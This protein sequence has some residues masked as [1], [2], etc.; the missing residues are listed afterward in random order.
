MSYILEDKN[1][2]K[3]RYI[4]VAQIVIVITQGIWKTYYMVRKWVRNH[5]KVERAYE[6]ERFCHFERSRAWSASFLIED[7]E[8]KYTVKVQTNEHLSRKWR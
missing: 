3:E 1:S 2:D 4:R 5:H 7:S 8:N 6:I